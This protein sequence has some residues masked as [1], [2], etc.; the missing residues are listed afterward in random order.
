[1][2]AWLTPDSSELE[3]NLRKRFI[4]L[5]GSLFVYISG[6]L[7]MLAEVEN[8]EDF[9]DLTA[10]ETADYFSDIFDEYTQS[11]YKMVGQITA[12]VRDIAMP[13]GWLPMTGQTLAQDDYPEL[14]AVVPAA[15][16]VSTNIVLPDLRGAFLAM[17]G[18]VGATAALGA[19]GGA[20]LKTL[21]LSEMPPHTHDYNIKNGTALAAAGA[22]S[23]V[24]P[25]NTIAS[26]DT[27]GGG[28]AFD[29]RPSYL[30][31][32]WGIYAGR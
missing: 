11:E 30:S 23:V 29:N 17:S 14:A 4:T 20:N 21:S 16:L 3:E 5:P 32:R 15:W 24:T 2:R 8:W 22:V 28:A 10:Q 13:N 7:M 26:T 9:G 1:M 19:M 31:I 18:A 12:W 6:A 25:G 27:S